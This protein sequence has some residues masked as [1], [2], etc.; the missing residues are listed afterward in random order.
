MCLKSLLLM[1]AA[2]LAIANPVMAEN[3]AGTFTLSPFFG[4]Q[5]FSSGST[6]HLDSDFKWGVRGGYNFTPNLGAELV[7][8]QNK[9]VHDPEVAHCD[10]YMYGADMLYHFRPG[11]DFVPF[12]AAGFGGFTVDYKSGNGLSDETKAYFNYGGG[13]EY[14]LT[15]WLALRGDFR[16]AILLDN[17]DGALEATAGLRFQFG[18]R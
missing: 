15:D 7:F 12:L 3:R 14:S 9:T 4:G 5:M 13:V 17:G 8:G 18:D 1:I 16:H 10:V 11:K 6:Y 2:L